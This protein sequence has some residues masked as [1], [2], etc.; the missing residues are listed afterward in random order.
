MKEKVRCQT[1]QVEKCR[2]WAGEAGR[3]P[4]GRQGTGGDDRGG[5][6]PG[7]QALEATMAAGGS[8]PVAAAG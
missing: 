6:G 7:W 1:R 2:V 4:A 3:K 8:V 5:G